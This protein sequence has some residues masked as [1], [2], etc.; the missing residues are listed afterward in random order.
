[1]R[2]HNFSIVNSRRNLTF[3][4]TEKM[5]DLPRFSP[6]RGQARKPWGCFLEARALAGG[7]MQ[8]EVYLCLRLMDVYQP[9][10]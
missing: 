5:T 1:M 9:G 10:R 6:R 3:R 4:Q 2:F 7:G 8:P